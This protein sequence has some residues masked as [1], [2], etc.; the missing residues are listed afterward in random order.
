MGVSAAG[1]SLRRMAVA[2]VADTL[3]AGGDTFASDEDPDLVREAA[4]FSLKL[5]ESLLAEV[6]SHRGLLLAACSGFTQYAYAFVQTDAALVEHED[7]ERAE[8]LKARARRMYLRAKAYCL[9]H[10]ELGYRGFA[11]RL[12]AD[13]AKAVQAVRREDVAGLYWTA[14]SWGAAIALG[15]DRP[16]LIADLPVVRALFAR[17][18]ALDEAF[19]EGAVHE[20]LIAIEALPEAMGGSAAR[21]REHFRRAVELSQGRAAGPYV[22]LASTVAVNEQNRAEF[23]R[24]LHAALA[25]DPDAVPRRRLA[26]LVA[27]RRA[28]YLLDHADL[29]FVSGPGAAARPGGGAPWPGPGRR[30]E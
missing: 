1:C 22:T 2:S 16:D 3:A 27:Q 21:A 6:P 19:G 14:A 18:L 20:A 13:P 28:R 24:L 8:A 5:M 23:E 7:F 30:E 4:P 9:R 12:A 15:L 10:L 26:N 25:I 17:A 29:L 11:A